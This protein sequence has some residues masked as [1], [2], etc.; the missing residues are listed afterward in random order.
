V[1][2]RNQCTPRASNPTN[3]PNFLSSAGRNIA[4]KYTNCVSARTNSRNSNIRNR[5]PFAA[6]ESNTTWHS[7]ITIQFNRFIAR[8]QL[9]KCLKFSLTADSGVTNTINAHSCDRALFYFTHAI[10]NSLHQFLI[11]LR[12]DTNGIIITINP[13]EYRASNMNN[14]LLLSLMPIITTIGLTCR[15]IAFNAFFC[16]PRNWNPKPNICF[17]CFRMLIC[18]I[19]FHFYFFSIIAFRIISAIYFINKAWRFAYNAES[20]MQNTCHS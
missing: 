9:I 1:L 13:L 3:V 5:Y 7:F 15:I 17:N 6:P 10:S 4:I 18:R 20:N 19:A 8:C 12:N 2:P 16:I 14:M 11:L